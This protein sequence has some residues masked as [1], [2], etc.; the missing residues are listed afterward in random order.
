LPEKKE[1]YAAERVEVSARSFAHCLIFSSETESWAAEH[2]LSW[3]A[4]G[5][6]KF[7]KRCVLLCFLLPVQAVIG[8][9]H[10]KHARELK[11]WKLK[12]VCAG[13]AGTGSPGTDGQHPLP[14][15]SNAIEFSKTSW[16]ECFRHYHQVW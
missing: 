4:C 15:L 5:S 10:W 8:N 16:P 7:K 6:G 12:R 3:L 9:D 1:K 14:S 11:A 2:N 13:T